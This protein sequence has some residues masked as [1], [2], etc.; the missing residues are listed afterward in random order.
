MRQTT[1]LLHGTTLRNSTDTFVDLVVWIDQ[2]RDFSV[3]SALILYLAT[4]ILDR[5]YIAQFYVRHSSFSSHF[6][7]YI[8]DIADVWT[9]ELHLSFLQLVTV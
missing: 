8:H 4:P 3:E 6:L 9:T 7:E 5:R 2:G 1:P